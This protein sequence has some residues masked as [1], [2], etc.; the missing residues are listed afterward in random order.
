MLPKPI[1]FENNKVMI[2]DQ[3]KLPENCVVKEM[4]TVEEIWQS[5]KKLEV[6]GAPAIGLAGAFGVYIGMKNWTEKE[7]ANKNDFLSKL[8]EI[9]DY[10]DTSRPT[11]VN[12]H[13][14]IERMKQK[15]KEI[16]QSHL[17]KEMSIQMMLQ[18][19]LNEAEIM[20]QEDIEAC[21]T[22]GEYGADILDNISGFKAFL[23][24]CNAGALAT[25]MYGTALAPAYIMKQR[26][27]EIKVFSDETRPLLQGSRLTAWEL[28][29]SGI[30]VTTIC[31]NMAGVVMKNKWVQAVITGA[32]RITKNGD[33]ANKIGTYSLSILAKEHNIPFFIAAPL[34]T[35]DFDME[36][37][38]EIPIEQRDAQEVRYFGEKQTA[39]SNVSIFNPAFD[40]TPH[41]NITAIITEKGVAYPP[42]SESLQAL[43]EGRKPKSTESIFKM[44][45][46]VLKTAKSIVASGLVSGTFGNISMI[47]RKKGFVAITP[48]GASYEDMTEKDI[49]ITDLEGN[50]YLENGKRPSSEL[51][52][53]LAVYKQREDIHAI[54]HTHSLYATVLASQGEKLPAVL[55][56][57]GLAGAGE[58]EVAAFAPPGS[59]ELA[60]ET[61]K[62]L[63][64]NYACLLANHGVVAGAQTLDR[65]FM[66]ASIV[67]EGAHVY[68]LERQSD[69]I[70]IVPKQA[71]EAVFKAMQQYGK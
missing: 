12:L 33:S 54:I 32:D 60:Y 58:I 45:K 11:A 29:Q 18:Q 2:L 68:Y 25:S 39:P 24:H 16:W 4:K 27:K 19:L 46:Q 26:G 48:S 42:F 53:H 38:E 40:V 43:R 10:I 7:N 23:T 1:W 34:S 41:Q 22:I 49:C 5:I 63:G 13:W 17:Q 65:A 8:I 20:L 21:K 36:T 35:I 6:R 61:V 44:Q 66:V 28:S 64:K 62:A 31:D 15:G 57:M 55:T 51:P 59:K 52:M 50:L 69:N 56:E 70:S 71:Y 47:D 14:A 37:G 9:G 3:T 67:E 30:D